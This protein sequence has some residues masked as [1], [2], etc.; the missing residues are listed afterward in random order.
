MHLAR[1][2]WV[3]GGLLKRVL[4]FFGNEPSLGQ[5]S[6]ILHLPQSVSTSLKQRE[7]GGGVV[8]L[9]L[10]ILSLCSAP[11]ASSTLICLYH[12]NVHNTFSNNGVIIIN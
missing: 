10:S 8:W 3:G 1:L 9:T 11:T 2:V 5:K 4:Y 6:P 12:Q 7:R